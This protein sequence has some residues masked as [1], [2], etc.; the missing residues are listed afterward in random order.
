[1]M[2]AGLVLLHEEQHPSCMI[3]NISKNHACCTLC[4]IVFLGGWLP[5]SYCGMQQHWLAA[6][7]TLMSVLANNAQALG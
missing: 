3:G 6:L 7:Y 2:T 1:M 4:L 5:W